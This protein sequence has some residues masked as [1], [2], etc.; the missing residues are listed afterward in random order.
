MNDNTTLLKMLYEEEVSDIR[1]VTHYKDP[2]LDFED[3]LRK[4]VG[5]QFVSTHFRRFMTVINMFDQ[6]AL[7]TG[8]DFF[9]ASFI[10]SQEEGIDHF[11]LG[12]MFA[13]VAKRLGFSGNKTVP[14]VNVYVQQLQNAFTAKVTGQVL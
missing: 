13:Q 2:N 12:C 8:E 5:L 7:I 9:Y 6:G 1:R 11:A 3:I 10:L 14:D 4:D